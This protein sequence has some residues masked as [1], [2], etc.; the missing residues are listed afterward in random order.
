MRLVSMPRSRRRL[1]GL[2]PLIDVVF[3]LLLFFM[4]ASQFNQWRA[5]TVSAAGRLADGG[6]AP[7][8]LVRVHGDGRLD[9]NGEPLASHSLAERLRQAL[10]REP[11]LSVQIESAD[12]VSL[13]DLVSVFDQLHA[14]GIERMSLR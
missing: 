8:M 9:L 14:A 13:Q 7:A 3:I 11:D 10:S 6:A 2:T 4:L 5:V 1:I 12:A